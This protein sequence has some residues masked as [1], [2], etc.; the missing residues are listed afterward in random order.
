MYHRPLDL[1][2]VTLSVSQTTDHLTYTLSHP[3]YY[4]PYTL[5]FTVYHRPLILYLVTPSV[6]QTTCLIPCH[7]QCITYTTCLTPCHT[8]CITDH[9]SYTLS[10][11]VY[12]RPLLLHLVTPSV[13]QTTC[14]ISCH[15]WCITD[16]VSYPALWCTANFIFCTVW[17]FK[18]HQLMHLDYKQF[19]C[20]LC[21]KSFTRKSD[22]V[23]HLTRFSD[24]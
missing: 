14:L 4:L 24:V 3:V 9:L 22:V 10:H 21:D 5:S 18:S 8:Q 23:K 15:S 7:S 11:P 20:R 13:S 2:L 12:H 1:Y 19:C 16:H 17:Q 6:S